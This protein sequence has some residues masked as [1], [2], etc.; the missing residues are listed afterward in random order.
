MIGLEPIKSNLP[1]AALVAVC[2]TGLDFLREKLD[3]K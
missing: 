3:N 1:V 2:K